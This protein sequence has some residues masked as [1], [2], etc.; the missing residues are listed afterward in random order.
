MSYMQS[1]QL[2]D[3]AL[4]VGT[5]FCVWLILTLVSIAYDRRRE[6]MRQSENVRRWCESLSKQTPE[7]K[8]D[9]Y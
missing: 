3:L 5:I 4:V 6:R 1:L 7:E 9:L 8:R 2:G